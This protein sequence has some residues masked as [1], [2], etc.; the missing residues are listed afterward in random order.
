MTTDDKDTLV[1]KWIRWL[2]NN[3]Y[4]AIIIFLGVVVGALSSSAESIKKLSAIFATSPAASGP[5]VPLPQAALDLDKL[6]GELSAAQELITTYKDKV[7]MWDS[8]LA[9]RAAQLNRTKGAKPQTDDEI[10]QIVASI[11]LQEKIIEESQVNRTQAVNHLA[12]QEA[13][14]R[15]LRERVAARP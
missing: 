15:V 2:K 7:Q 3:P 6:R 9:D 13:R 1:D 14:A 10:R 11:S 5:Q 4:I 12:D 8:Y